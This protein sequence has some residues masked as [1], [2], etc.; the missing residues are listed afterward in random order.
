MNN[1]NNIK[2]TKIGNLIEVDL[3]TLIERE[4]DSKIEK[5]FKFAEESSFPSVNALFEDVYQ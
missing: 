2:S 5:A 3:R 4:C 1:P